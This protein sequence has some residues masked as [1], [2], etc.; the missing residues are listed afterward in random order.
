MS[1]TIDLFPWDHFA[2]RM[3]TVADVQAF[4]QWAHRKHGGAVDEYEALVSSDTDATGKEIQKA[5]EEVYRWMCRADVAELMLDYVMLSEVPTDELVPEWKIAAQEE[6]IELPPRAYEAARTVQ[7]WIERRME[8]GKED[9]LDDIDEFGALFERAAGK[10][11]DPKKL[12]DAL[13]K[14][15]SRRKSWPIDDTEALIRM[16]RNRE[17]R[18]K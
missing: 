7:E 9:L 2:S 15:L 1:D 12:K 5:Y 8:K 3:E 6:P 18:P 13:Q 10:D 17:I 16:L 11:Q 14:S 4:Y